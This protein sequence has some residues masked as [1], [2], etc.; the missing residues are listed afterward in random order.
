M[1]GWGE[2]ASLTGHTTG[3]YDRAKFSEYW[4]DKWRIWFNKGES[5][6]SLTLVRLTADRGEFWSAPQ[7]TRI[8]HFFPVRNAHVEAA[9]PQE[10]SG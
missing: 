6:Q 10:I 3:V 2:F 1:S 4:N 9:T 7:A 8:K 5:D